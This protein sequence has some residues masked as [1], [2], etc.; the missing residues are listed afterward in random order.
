MSRRDL[1][2]LTDIL[3]AIEAIRAHLSHGDLSSGLVFDAVRVGLIEIGEAVKGIT[4]S[5]LAACRTFHGQTL[6]RCVTTWPTATSTPLTRSCKAPSAPTS[7]HSKTRSV[8]HSTA[9]AVSNRALI[10]LPPE[11]RPTCAGFLPHRVTMRVLKRLTDHAHLTSVRVIKCVRPTL[12]DTGFNPEPARDAGS[13]LSGYLSVQ[14]P[15][16]PDSLEYRTPVSLWSVGNREHDPAL[17]ALA[18]AVA[19]H[20]RTGT[21][22]S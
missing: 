14:M 2:R 22:G 3:V 7:R 21:P 17:D 20:R 11:A 9:A 1:E 10:G 6:P 15:I 5:A 12:G 16:S 19:R 8:A 4:P 18:G 13:W